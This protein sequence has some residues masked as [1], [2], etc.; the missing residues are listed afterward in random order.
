MMRAIVLG[1]ADATGIATAAPQ[2]RVALHELYRFY[3]PY[4]LDYLQGSNDEHRALVRA[5]R[6]HDPAAAVHV[7]HGHITC[8]HPSMFIGLTAT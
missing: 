1:V 3:L 7:T 2:L 5:L 6:A 4:P 8:L